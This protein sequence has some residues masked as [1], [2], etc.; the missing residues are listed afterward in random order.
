[1]LKPLFGAALLCSLASSQALAQPIAPPRSTA[2]STRA[3]DEIRQSDSLQLGPVYVE[4]AIRLKELGVDTNVFNQWENEKSDFTFTVTPRADVALPIARA[5]LVKAEVA[6]DLVYFAQFVSERSVDPRVR[7]RAERYAQRLTMF[8]EESYENTRE[9]PS[10][11]IDV[12]ARHVNNTLSAGTSIGVASR[13]SV[14]VAAR[15]RST[16]FDGDEFSGSQ[17]LKETLDRDSN[18]FSAVTF[19]ERNVLTSLGLLTEYQTDRFVESPVRD[20]NSF[21]IMPGVTMQ[22]RALV[23]GAAWIGYR[24][25][26]PQSPELRSWSG[27]VSRLVLSHTLLGATVFA[28]T[29][30]R[31]YQWSVETAFPY[32]IDNGLRASIR[33]AIGSRYDVIVSATRH[34]YDYQGLATGSPD[35]PPLTRVDRVRNYGVDVGYRVKRQ[36]RIG[37]GVSWWERESSQ[38]VLQNYEDLRIGLTMAYEL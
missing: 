37:F 10:Y 14:E 2:G 35:V 3:I 13:M 34:K 7:V 30:D 27:L 11:E 26:K 25:F 19:F 9:R 33:R 21:R 28:V 32:F 12:R 22:P 20:T 17:Y 36:T 29:Y 31:D 8:V 16:R 15:H 38:R 5:G 1:M 23:N 24:A 6:A 4:P 18:T